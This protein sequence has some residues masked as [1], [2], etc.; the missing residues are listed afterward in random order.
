MD[1]EESEIV[2]IELYYPQN[3]DREHTKKHR[4]ARTGYGSCQACDCKGYVDSG[5]ILWA[6]TC[7]CRHH[8][9]VH[10]EPS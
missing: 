6:G 2:R 5:A 10:N 4:P 3:D 8:F 7:T 9:S 1:T